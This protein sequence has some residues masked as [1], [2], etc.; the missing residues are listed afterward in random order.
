MGQP[1]PW[2]CGED[3]TVDFILCGPDLPTRILRRDWAPLERETEVWDG[4][5]TREVL[6][7]W[8]WR[9]RGSHCKERRRPPADRDGPWLTIR[10]RAS[11]SHNR[12]EPNAA[13]SLN[14][15]GRTFSLEPSEWS[16]AWS[17]P[18]FGLGDPEQRSLSHCAWSSGLHLWLFSC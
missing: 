15:L 8:L 7:C 5:S 4:L 18:R 13:N 6:C 14:E 1:P 17:T 12:K 10:K 11:Q 9:C 2:L 3:G 16:A